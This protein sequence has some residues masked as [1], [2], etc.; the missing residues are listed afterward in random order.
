MWKQLRKY[1]VK[2]IP[3][4]WKKTN[5]AEVADA[6]EQNEP[7]HPWQFTDYLPVVSSIVLY[8]RRECGISRRDLE[9]TV[10]DHMEE[11]AWRIKE[12][13]K[14]LMKDPQV[15][16]LITDRPGAFAGMEEE[17]MEGYGLPFVVLENEEL[18]RKSVV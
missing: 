18:D 4:Y 13:L 8:M 15:L 16:Y 9:L 7:K 17:L 2:M 14:D 6:F 11:P 1:L 5:N 10:I 12:I 3:K